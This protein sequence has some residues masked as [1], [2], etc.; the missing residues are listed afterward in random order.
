M[1]PASCRARVLT[2]CTDCYHQTPTHT[3]LAHLHA[4]HPT[5]H[6]RPTT[7]HLGDHGGA[8]CSASP[9]LSLAMPPASCRARVLT[10]CTD[11]YHQ[12]PT[13]TT[14]AH[15]HARHPT[16]HARP[17][18]THLGDHGGAFCS[19]S[20]P[21]SL[22]MPPAR[23]R[24]QLPTCCTDCYHQAPSHTTLA[25]ACTTA[26]VTRTSTAPST[27]AAT[28]WYQFW[29]IGTDASAGAAGTDTPV[30][31]CWHAPL[32]PSPVPALLP[33]KQRKLQG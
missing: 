19:A 9:P 30:S 29:A 22:A 26:A 16:R 33:A 11:C 32:L 6:A 7:T 2:F 18:T 4:R 23:P 8:F 25:L 27:S 17:T 12:T 15:L 13:H 31:S 24:A 3:T 28:R 5:R 1:P 10:F 14:L 20:P 21:L